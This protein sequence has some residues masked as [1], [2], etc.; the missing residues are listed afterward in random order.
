[1][2]SHPHKFLLIKNMKKLPVKYIFLGLL[3]LAIIFYNIAFPFSFINN[4]RKEYIPKEI[5]GVIYDN[6]RVR[7]GVLSLKLHSS[8]GDKGISIRNSDVVLNMIS[9]GFYFKKKRNSNKCY[10]IKGDSIM[11]FNCYV[12]SK[13]DSI[14]IG[15]I[16]NWNSD[17]TNHW[18]LK[19]GN[20]NKYKDFIK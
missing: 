8:S 4:M 6:I 19:D 1:M 7:G 17:Y 10:V 9:N 18:M 3:F 20:Q 14:K 13:E 12:F 5:G 11:F 16:E 15:D 2:E